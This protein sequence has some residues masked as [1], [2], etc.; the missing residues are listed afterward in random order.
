M[1]V[2]ATGFTFTGW[3]KDASGTDPTVI[4]TVDKNRKVVAH[5]KASP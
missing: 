4:V 5:F 3:S 2:A 1:A